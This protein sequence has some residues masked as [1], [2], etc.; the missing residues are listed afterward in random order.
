MEHGSKMDWFFLVYHDLLQKKMGIR[1]LYHDHGIAHIWTSLHRFWSVGVSSLYRTCWNIEKQHNNSWFQRLQNF[2]A[3]LIWPYHPKLSR[4]GKPWRSSKWNNLTILP[5]HIS[6]SLQ[7]AKFDPPQAGVP[8]IGWLILRW[9][10]FFSVCAFFSRAFQVSCWDHLYVYIHI[11]SYISY[12]YIYIHCEFMCTIM[13]I[14][15]YGWVTISL[16]LRS[17]QHVYCSN[18]LL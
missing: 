15:F 5:L 11:Q 14:K 13:Y 4:H 6:H 12:I 18:G 7:L 3:G 9:P 8:T 10:V 1:W 17:T 2:F 16:E